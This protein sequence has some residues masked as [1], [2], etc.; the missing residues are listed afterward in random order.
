M[1]QGFSV[2]IAPAKI[3]RA[4]DDRR[5]VRG[6][7]LRRAY[8]QALDAI[9]R[10]SEAVESK[11]AP[12]ARRKEILEGS[13]IGLNPGVRCL[14]GVQAQDETV[15]P[16]TTGIEISF[17]D[18]AISVIDKGIIARATEPATQNRTNLNNKTDHEAPEQLGADV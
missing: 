12:T 6:R 3:D 13:D 5:F 16:G 7:S 17:A 8:G 9:R 4:A 10:Q 1:T 18:I 2:L 15:V 11:V 14:I